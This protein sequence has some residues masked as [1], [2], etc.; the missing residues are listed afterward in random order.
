M[1]ATSEVSEFQC[2]ICPFRLDRPV[3]LAESLLAQSRYLQHLERH[4]LEEKRPG[5]R[6]SASRFGDLRAPRRIERPSNQAG[7]NQG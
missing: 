7:G 3:D 1:A 2:P 6:R 4:L 5:P